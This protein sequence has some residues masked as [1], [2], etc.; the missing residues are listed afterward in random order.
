MRLCGHI[1]KKN[2]P[3]HAEN[4]KKQEMCIN[5]GNGKFGEDIAVCH[6]ERGLD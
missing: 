4:I 2:S 1:K 6:V 3:I 5:I